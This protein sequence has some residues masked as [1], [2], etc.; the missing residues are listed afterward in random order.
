L[1]NLLAFSSYTQEVSESLFKTFCENIQPWDAPEVMGE[2]PGSY[3]ADYLGNWDPQIYSDVLEELYDLALI[4]NYQ[5][6]EDGL[7]TCG[8]HSLVKD[9][10]RLRLDKVEVL[11]Y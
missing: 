4:D 8:I 10:I 9:W 1:L 5:L 7:Y 3:L 11:K 2:S 6:G